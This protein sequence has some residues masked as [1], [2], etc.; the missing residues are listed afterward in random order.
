LRLLGPPAPA[1]AIPTASL[2][3]APPHDGMTTRP[4]LP[5]YV[6]SWA[7]LAASSP[8]WSSASRASAQSRLR[9]PAKPQKA[10]GQHAYRSTTPLA[11]PRS[12]QARSTR[13]AHWCTLVV[14]VVGQPA[15]GSPP[16][17]VR[18]RIGHRHPRTGRRRTPAG[19]RRGDL[20]APITGR[21]DP[22]PQG[23]QHH[24]DRPPRSTCAQWLSPRA[25]R[26]M[27]SSVGLGITTDAGWQAGC[28]VR[29]AGGSTFWTMAR[30][31]GGVC[32]AAP[33]SK[34]RK[35]RLQKSA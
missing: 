5:G 7:K 6:G 18:R 14:S 2:R 1:R 28:P 16:R 15:C 24:R 10:A 29:M 3:M 11:D 17:R 33:T 26:Q 12:D 13:P 25:R 8:C 21:R 30:A 4:R 9:A 27:S 22:H 32:P 20:L 34:T 23:W 19:S 35:C 31:A